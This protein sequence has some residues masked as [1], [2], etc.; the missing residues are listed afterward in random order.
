VAAMAVPVAVARAVPVDAPQGQL[1]SEN[2]ASKGTKLVDRQ[3]TIITGRQET[4]GT[5]PISANIRVDN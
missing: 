1:I 5:R 2:V 4:I 3:D